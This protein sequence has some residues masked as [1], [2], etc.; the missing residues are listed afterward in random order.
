MSHWS[1]IVHKLI[2]IHCPMFICYSNDPGSF[3][4]VQKCLNPDLS[5]GLGTIFFHV[6]FF[7]VQL[8]TVNQ[9]DSDSLPV[10]MQ[11]H[12]YLRGVIYKFN[13]K[14]INLDK[15]L[16]NLT[17]QL[18]WIRAGTGTRDFL[19][20]PFFFVFLFLSS[21]LALFLIYFP[22]EW[23]YMELQVQEILS[24]FLSFWIIP[25]SRILQSTRNLSGHVHGVGLR[26]VHFDSYC[27]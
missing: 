26:T 6:F 24:F 3:I 17:S 18:T 5:L 4:V 1:S 27:L 15:A 8:Q 9:L 22:L 25:Q 10:S 13:L 12:I 16:S 11:I 2:G 20:S 14:K 19:K 7:A 23:N 21:S